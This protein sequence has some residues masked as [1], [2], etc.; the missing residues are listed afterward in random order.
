M[1]GTVTADSFM[2]MGEGEKEQL[3]LVAGTMRLWKGTRNGEGSQN[4]F[5]PKSSSQEAALA[6]QEPS[7]PSLPWLAG[8]H[9]GLEPSGAW[10]QS[11]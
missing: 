6:P 3:C 10:C 7:M 11:P 8:C 2:P 5:L 4:T 1:Q 9:I